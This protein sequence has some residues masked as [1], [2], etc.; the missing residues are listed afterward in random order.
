MAK[1]MFL[2]GALLDAR[3]NKM[4]I[5]RWLELQ[6]EIDY[7]YFLLSEIYKKLPKSPIDQMVDNASGYDTARKKEIREICQEMKELKAEWNKETGAAVSTDMED[8]I[9]EL[10]KDV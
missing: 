6:Q 9:L 5:P 3:Q 7:R 8:Q 4:E 2:N 10:V 1:A